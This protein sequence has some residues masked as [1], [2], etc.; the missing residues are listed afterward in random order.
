MTGNMLSTDYKALIIGASGAIGNAF[1]DAFQKDLFCL[2]VETISRSDPRFKKDRFDLSVPSSIVKHAALSKAG[3]PYQIIVD[4]T[5]ALHIDGIGPEKS[6]A[7]LQYDHLMRAFQTNTIGPALVL[8]QFAPLLATGPCIYAKLS[9]RVGSI[10]DN[11]KGGWYG[12][13]SSKAAMN[14][15]LQTAALELQRKNPEAMIVALQPGTVRSKLS[16]PFSAHVD[17]L[18]EPEESVSGMLTALKMLT[19]KKGAHFIDYQGQ[20]IPW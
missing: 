7:G 12:Y 9:A 17:N 10:T 3:G 15:I 16:N 2:H 20:E 5:G 14:M 1:F 6:L 4:A 8:Q 11:R 19:P 18:L 13:R